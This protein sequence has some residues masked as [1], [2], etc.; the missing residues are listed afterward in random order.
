MNDKEMRELKKELMKPG[1]TEDLHHGLEKLPQEVAAKIVDSMTDNEI[2]K[3]VNNRLHQ[4]DYIA[5]YL[6]YLWEIN[7][8]AFWRQVKITIDTTIGLL[9][10]DNMFYAE[11]MCKEKIPNDVLGAVI[12]YAIECTDRDNQDYEA[13]GCIIKAQV[14]KFD[15]ISEIDTF[16]MD[17][18]EEQIKI[19]KQRIDYLLK[20][21]CPYIF[22]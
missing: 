5:D 11:I 10:S 18:D 6:S 2:Y 15:R 4:E 1:W 9:W 21:E 7:K 3:K 22:Y 13:V 14:E 12:K 8:Q 16:L 20:C 19:A 17:L